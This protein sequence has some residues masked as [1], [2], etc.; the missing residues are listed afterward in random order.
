MV[1]DKMIN[2]GLESVGREEFAAEKN[3]EIYFGRI[4]D[5]LDEILT[6][7]SRIHL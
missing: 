2:Y 1:G 4:G 3:H 6:T 7:T 5:V